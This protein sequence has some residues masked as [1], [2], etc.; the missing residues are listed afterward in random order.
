MHKRS[1]ISNTQTI[2]LKCNHVITSTDKTS[3]L[4]LPLGSE[5][6]LSKAVPVLTELQ[7]RDIRPRVCAVRTHLWELANLTHNHRLD[8]MMSPC[9]WVTRKAGQLSNFW[10]FHQLSVA[11]QQIRAV[12][13]ALAA[14]AAVNIPGSVVHVRIFLLKLRVPLGNPVLPVIWLGHLFSLVLRNSQ[15]NAGP[16]TGTDLTASTFLQG[17]TCTPAIACQK[18]SL[19]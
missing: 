15:R 11:S 1:S 10:G 13:R 2:Q 5:T 17:W 7:Q 3:Y 4:N 9:L 18:P 12:P 14:E 6:A 8:E 16:D 19:I